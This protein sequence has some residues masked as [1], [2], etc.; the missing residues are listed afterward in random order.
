MHQQ[1]STQ[2]DGFPHCL[3]D[4][5]MYNGYPASKITAFRGTSELSIHQ[6]SDKIVTRGILIDIA[7]LKNV[8]NLEKGYN[9]TPADLDAAC[10]T[11]KV[12]VISGDIVCVRTGWLNVMRKWALPLRG[13]EPYQ[14]GE[15]GIGLQACKWLKE[16]QV[17]AI[18][19][20]NLGVEVIPFD[21]DDVNKVSD[22]GVK[23]FPVHVELL[24]HQGMPLGEMWDFEALAKSCA[25]DGVYEFMIVAPPLRIVGGVGSPL[26]PIAI[27]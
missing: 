20:D 9:I 8:P 21:P 4:G 11:Q 10:M 16:K 22:K 23:S 25:E 5:K 27:K 13:K 14:L 1:Y 26:S 15:P 12:K 17:A 7:R 19:C 24:V 6:W 3:W 2:W 18:A